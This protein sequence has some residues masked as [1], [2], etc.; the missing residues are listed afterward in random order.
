MNLKETVW[1]S[2]DWIDLAQDKNTFR[3][4]VMAEVTLRVT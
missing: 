4:I 3:A 2:V 1:E